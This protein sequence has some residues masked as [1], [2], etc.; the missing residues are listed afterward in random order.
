MSSNERY[1]CEDCG[2]RYRVRETLDRYFCPGCGG[3]DVYRDRT[4]GACGRPVHRGWRYCPTCGVQLAV[5]EAVT[6]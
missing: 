5:A 1:H 3:V 4:C 2:R 6:E